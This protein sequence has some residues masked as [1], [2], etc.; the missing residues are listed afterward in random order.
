MAV[1]KP[2][3]ACQDVQWSERM[4][5]QAVALQTLKRDCLVLVDNCN[6]TGHECDVLAV[7]RDL[8]I[9]DVEVKISRADFKAD[10]RKEKWWQRRMRWAGD[11][12]PVGT[13]TDLFGPVQRAQRTHPPRV[14][15]HYFAMPREIWRE[16]MADLLPSPACGVLLLEHGRPGH[17]VV[18]SHRRVKPDPHAYRLTAA[19]AIDIARLASLRLWGAY[20]TIERYRRGR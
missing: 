4:I 15:K 10:A 13:G 5:A 6:W 19:Q 1:V 9:I 17:V 20:D 8:R 11:K 18:T 3:P 2:K 7:T 14:W 16:D 12:Q